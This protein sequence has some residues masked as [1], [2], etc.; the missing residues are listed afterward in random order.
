[1]EVT[2]FLKRVINIISNSVTSNLS[3]KATTEHGRLKKSCH[4][5]E[6]NFATQSIYGGFD[7]ILDDIL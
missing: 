3:R 2:T 7:G 5:E 4:R 6:L 1:M